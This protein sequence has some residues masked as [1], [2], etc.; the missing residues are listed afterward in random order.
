[1]KDPT[2]RFSSKV[3]NYELYRPEYPAE[4]LESLRE[5]CGISSN[6][7]VADVGSGTGI[8]SRMFLEHGCRVF[9]VEPN[10]EMRR[11]GERLLAGYER[12]ESVAAM[13]E[14]TTLAD[15]SVDFVTAGQ[16]FH[17]F[18]PAGAR[19]E[20]GRILKPAGWVMLVWN[21]PKTDG[22]TFVA[23]YERMLDA[24]GTDF[25]AVKARS[26]SMEQRM[27]AF[28]EPRDYE[29]R[30]F[31]NRQTLDF[32]GLRGRLLSSS[33]VPDE[34]EPGHAEMLKELAKIFAKHAENGIVHVGY[35]T[36]A[37]YGQLTRR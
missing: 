36:R 21:F 31:E 5:G 30:A 26:R 24:Y 10:E 32:D 35:D 22:S 13:A 29:T 14:A 17:W 15:T 16:A 18:D 19:A 25:E 6:S 34:G 1:M 2:R 7:V 27:R 20:F 4:V 33:Y 37:Y 23:A 28:F 11:A 3:E 12:F 8:L 9:G